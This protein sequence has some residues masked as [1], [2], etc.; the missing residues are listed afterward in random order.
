MTGDIFCAW[1]RPLGVVYFAMGWRSLHKASR[2]AASARLNGG[3]LIETML[4]TDERG[5]RFANASAF[6]AIRVLEAAVA[7]P[8]FEAT[9][10]VSGSGGAAALRALRASKV[11]AIRAG[12][13]AYERVVFLDADT[14]VCRSLRPVICALEPPAIA[15][16]APVDVGR[17][18]GAALLRGRWRVPRGAREPN[19]GVLAV[20]NDT[21]AL[22]LMDA[23][24]QAYDEIGFFM[25]QPA[26]RAAL[27]ATGAP[28]GLLSFQFNCRGHQRRPPRATS[29]HVTA[30]PLR[31]R[32]FDRLDG[33]VQTRL[34]GGAG[35]V[36]L[37]SHDIREPFP[38]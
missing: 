27:H 12:L 29:A 34:N 11:D 8:E 5:R 4:V 10:A 16:F 23:W 20:R 6:N 35:C 7:V 2:S 32:G 19:T 9:R 31:C 33:R 30:V 38:P 36:V 26:L 17:E 24:R 18:H 21:A 15:A 13:E 1:R 14:Y 37:H 28:H 22:A 25:D 3:D